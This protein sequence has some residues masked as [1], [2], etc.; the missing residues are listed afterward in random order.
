MKFKILFLLLISSFIF[1]QQDALKLFPNNGEINGW[2]RSGEIRQFVG[3]KLWEYIDGGAEFYHIYGFK[4]VLTCDYKNQTKQIVVDIYEM[5]D[6]KNAFGIYAYERDPKYKFINIGVQGY[7]SDLSLNFWKGSFYIKLSVFDKSADSKNAL[8]SFAKIVE[9]KITGTFT[10]PTFAG[11][12]P[13]QNLIENSVKYFPKDILGNSFL[14]N[15]FVAEYKSKK[16]SFKAFI[17]EAND[18]KTA[19]NFLIQY[20]NYLTKK[21]TFE[22]DL[23]NLGSG[24]FMGK[25]NGKK[26][27]VFYNQKI[28]SGVIGEDD[29]NKAI[30]ILNEINKK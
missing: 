11:F 23:N 7:T 25:D 14:Y 8:L 18:P 6:P 16:N 12:F 3:E 9:K 20:K 19:Q 4:K 10:T 26:L 15:G 27:V 13:K 30:N 17:L 2:N 28:C 29:E 22:K 5:K 21:K 1:A 24:A